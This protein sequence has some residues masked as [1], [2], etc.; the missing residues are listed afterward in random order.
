MD[1]T[2]LIQTPLQTYLLLVW[3]DE[4]EGKYLRAILLEADGHPV[5]RSRVP[6]SDG[7]TLEQIPQAIAV[8]VMNM[9]GSSEIGTYEL[10]VENP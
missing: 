7:N 10:V 5:S 8:S 4:G 3:S 2:L 6:E 1:S 9:P